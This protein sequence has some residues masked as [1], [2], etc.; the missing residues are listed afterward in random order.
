MAVSKGALSQFRYCLWYRSSH[1]TDSDIA[2]I[3][4]PVLATE[5]GSWWPLKG[6]LM[7]VTV[8]LKRL[9]IENKQV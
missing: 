7:E 9:G 4:G 8:P 3:A 5:I 6:F 1:G 2:E